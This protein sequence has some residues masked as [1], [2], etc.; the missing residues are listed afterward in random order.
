MNGELPNEIFYLWIKTKTY[1]WTPIGRTS[2]YS[3]IEELREDNNFY[4]RT[5]EKR[6]LSIFKAVLYLEEIKQ[7][8]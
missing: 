6:K 7:E 8:D 4:F 2:G 1:G 3:S 5:E